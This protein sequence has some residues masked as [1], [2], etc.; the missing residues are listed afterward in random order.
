MKLFGKNCSKGKEKKSLAEYEPLGGTAHFEK[1]KKRMVHRIA[2]IVKHQ[3]LERGRKQQGGSP[4][5]VLFMWVILGYVTST[6][7]ITTHATN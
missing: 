3:S 1:K 2:K 4:F 7:V 5:Y 6:D